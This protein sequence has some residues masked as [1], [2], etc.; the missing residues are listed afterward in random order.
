MAAIL[1]RFIA[2]APATEIAPFQ[3]A[4]FLKQPDRPI[5][6]RDRNFW[7][8]PHRASVKLFHVRMIARFGEDARDDPALPCQSQA[9]FDAQTLDARFHRTPCKQ[10]FFRPV[11]PGSTSRPTKAE[12]RA[13]GPVRGR[14]RLRSRSGAALSNID[15]G[16]GVGT[17]VVVRPNAGHAPVRRMR[18]SVL[19]VSRPCRYWPWCPDRSPWR[20]RSVLRRSSAPPSGNSRPGP[21][22]PDTGPGSCRRRFSDAA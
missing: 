22:A 6:R 3:D 4:F 10:P 12:Q 8:E 2:R 5:H 11:G 16:T 19:M 20:A 21:N 17:G 9:P 18:L 13:L 15:M 1:G 7:V 14:M